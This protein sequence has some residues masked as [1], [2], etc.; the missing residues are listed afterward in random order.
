MFRRRTSSSGEI[1]YR[2]NINKNMCI[3]VVDIYI[4]GKP[5]LPGFNG[6]HLD[7]YRDKKIKTISISGQ[8]SYINPKSEY[9]VILGISGGVIDGTLTYQYDSGMHCELANKVIYGN[10]II[11]FVPIL[12]I[13]DPGEIIDFTYRSELQTQVLEERSVSWDGDYVLNDNCIATDLCSGCESYA[14]G[15]SFRGN[16]RVMVRIV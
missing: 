9:N 3:S 7:I 16:Y 6:Y 5:Y 11:N 15:K 2:V 14:Y 12:I 1:H 10:R 4:D 8:I 13:E